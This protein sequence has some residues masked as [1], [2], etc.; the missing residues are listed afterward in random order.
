M[1]TEVQKR[2]KDK[3]RRTHVAV[4]VDRR[5]RWHDDH[6]VYITWMGMKTRCS[7]K[8][9]RSYKNWGARGITVC[10]EWLEYRV[11]ERWM[12]EHGW[13]SGLTIDRI[14]NNGNYEPENCRITTIGENSSRRR[15]KAS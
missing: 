15:K 13:Q 5:K 8:N 14:D 12:I 3:Y 9:H 7:N 11:F 1:S 4:L 6:P 10:Q 2:A